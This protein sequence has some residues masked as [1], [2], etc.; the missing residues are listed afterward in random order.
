MPTGSDAEAMA[1]KH[2]VNHLAAAACASGMKR[3]LPPH[4]QGE[5]LRGGLLWPRLKILDR[6][7]LTP[8]CNGFGVD[9]Q[10][11]A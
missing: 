4:L 10:F 5:R 6:R 7:T 11:L 8:L 1:A 2:R 9:T 3:S